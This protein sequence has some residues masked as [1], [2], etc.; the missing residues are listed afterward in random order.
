[1][2]LS[3]KRTAAVTGARGL[4]GQAIIKHLLDKGWQVRALTRSNE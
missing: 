3:I 4:V 1:M 2:T